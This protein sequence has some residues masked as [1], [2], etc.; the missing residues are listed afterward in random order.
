M[1]GPNDPAFVLPLYMI[2]LFFL[3][4]PYAAIM[5]FQAECYDADCRATGSAFISAFS[6]P[7]A[8]IGGFILTAIVAASFE[9]STAALVVGAV[10][11]FVSGLVML[12]AKKVDTDVPREGVPI[13]AL[14]P[15]DDVAQA[16]RNN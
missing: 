10:G 2:G 16:L 9:F 6:Q 12:A 4:G 7:G 13:P 3:L 5:Y 8:V 1:L 15:T 14:R 11:T